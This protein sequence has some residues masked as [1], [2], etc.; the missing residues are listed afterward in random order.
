M[1]DSRFALIVA[2][3]KSSDSTLTKLLAPAHDA[4]SLATVLGEPTIGAFQVRTLIDQPAVT[5]MQE[6]E[7]FFDGRARDDLVLLYFSGHGILDQSERLYFATV[8]TQVDRPR[9]TAFRRASS[10]MSCASLVRG[11]RTATARSRS[12]SCTTTSTSEWSTHRHGSA[13][14]SG[15]SGSKDGSSS[16]RRRCQKGRQGSRGLLQP[17]PQ[18]TGGKHE[19]G[20]LSR[21]ATPCAPSRPAD[22]GPRR[23][24]S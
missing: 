15:P 10:T 22:G 11:G 13:P 7:A 5:T 14:A 20:G 17:R 4:K 6:I 12:T 16:R 21:T 2:S 3:S 18:R 23:R 24:T 9:S 19:R 8:D 1:A